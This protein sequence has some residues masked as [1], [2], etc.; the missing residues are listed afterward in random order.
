M[1][2]N[3]EISKFRV[4]HAFLSHLDIRMVLIVGR[5]T[6]RISIP[7]RNGIY[8]TV[9]YFLLGK[10]VEFWIRTDNINKCISSTT[11][12]YLFTYSA[13]LNNW[14]IEVLLKPIV[15]GLNLNVRMQSTNYITT[16]AAYYYYDI[17]KFDKLKTLMSNCFQKF[18]RNPC[19]MAILEM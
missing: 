18:T 8:P 2:R 4:W 11:T 7:T 9:N 17:M 19:T 5:K 14:V 12:H 10:D 3:V 1:P 16:V 15:I 13:I 6:K